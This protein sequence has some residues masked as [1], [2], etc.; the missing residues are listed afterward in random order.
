MIPSSNWITINRIATRILTTKFCHPNKPHYHQWN[1]IESSPGEILC[2]SSSPDLHMTPPGNDVL[3]SWCRGF[4]SVQCQT[5][6]MFGPSKV[7]Q[8]LI[9]F[10]LGGPLR[11]HGNLPCF[12]DPPQYFS[13]GIFRCL[14]PL[15]PSKMTG[16]WRS[17]LTNHPK[18][19]PIW[20]LYSIPK[21]QVG[22]IYHKPQL[23][24]GLWLYPHP[25]GRGLRPSH[26]PRPGSCFRDSAIR[27]PPPTHPAGR[28][29]GAPEACGCARTKNIRHI[30]TFMGFVI[31][32]VII[33]WF[34]LLFSRILF[35]INVM[36]ILP[37]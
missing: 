24:D 14:A 35:L 30:P 17:T 3:I 13:F 34:S 27:R 11:R 22:I 12:F 7:H 4:K 1:K 2:V 6:V 21:S 8:I 15:H 33:H 19:Q 28:A 29:P 36:N 9:P 20:G 37:R 10:T 32:F 5:N 26:L 16:T 23:R 25:A 31:I 18:Y